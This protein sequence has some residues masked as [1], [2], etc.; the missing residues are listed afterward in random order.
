MRQNRD[1]LREAKEH[2]LRGGLLLTGD[3][4]RG[5][6]Q[7]IERSWRRSLS[8]GVTP[9]L[10]G[11]ADVA[12]DGLD[13]G[14]V[15]A[16]RPVITALADQLG[17]ARVA[18]VLSDA[19]GRIVDRIVRNSAQ[20]ARLDRAGAVIGSNFSENAVGTNGL[21]SVVEE[22]AAMFVRGAEHFLE[23]LED[24]SCA[25][26]PIFDPGT[27]RIRGS[28]SL[29]CCNSDTSPLM[30]TLTHTVV[31]DIEARLMADRDRGLQDL[32]T[33]FA[34]ASR[35][36]AGP[37]AM[38]TSRTVLANTAGLPYLSAANHAVIWDRLLTDRVESPRLIRLDLLE[39]VVDL[40]AQR[41]PV[42]DEEYAF[43]VAIAPVR[44]Q[45]RRAATARARWH[46][47]AAIEHEMRALAQ[48][49]PVLVLRGE[50]GVGKTHAARQLLMGRPIVE[51]D[52]MAAGPGPDGVAAD[53][54]LPSAPDAARLEA[55]WF[56]AAC[57]DLRSGSSVIL[58]HVEAIPAGGDAAL[59]ALINTA[60]RPAPDGATPTASPV[61]P[62]RDAAGADA[63]VTSRLVLTLEAGPVRPGLEILLRA[64]AGQ[65]E[66]PPLRSTRSV[67]PAL[68]AACLEEMPQERRCSI[69]PPAMQALAR[70]EWP[71]N[72]GELRR[73]VQALAARYP[74]AVVRESDLPTSLTGQSRA[75]S[76]SGI[77]R[78]ERQA[79]LDA[80]RIAGSNR[81]EAARILGIGR[82]TLYRKLRALR[83]DD[84][85]LS[86]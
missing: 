78:S 36:H 80:L 83:I 71:G 44:A 74:R 54:A 41:V 31:R 76:L 81:A 85:E 69:A 28:L 29:T 38:L 67:I 43:Q 16:A 62:P 6:P 64:S 22:R 73:A 21:G 58:R 51:V 59:R 32:A 53:P 61:D 39:G 10:H 18:V 52:A 50:R 33:A 57:A 12:E 24:L 26:V 66:I 37:I 40:R 34:L 63:L 68:V 25:G 48:A 56:E 70:Q 35:G 47:V 30:L 75:R 9:D 49:S 14:L 55:V 79:I 60:Q 82:T 45:R 17:D 15:A 72:I 4:L 86:T 5:L 65:V 77:E 11:G 13:D 46:P 3:G 19:T 20:R 2:L 27:R 23:A 84:D 1:N 8:Q 42:V 7:P